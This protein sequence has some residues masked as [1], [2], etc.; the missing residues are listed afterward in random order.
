MERE[1]DFFGNSPER[2]EKK[3]PKIHLDFYF[4]RHSTK[5]DAKPLKKRFAKAD[6][7]SPE[8]IGPNEQLEPVL[9]QLSVGE[10]TLEQ[11][12]LKISEIIRSV[13]NPNN[14]KPKQNTDYKESY[15]YAIYKL[16]EGSKKPVILPDVSDI[17]FGD[18]VKNSFFETADEAD[19]LFVSGKFEDAVKKLTIGIKK[20]VELAITEREKYFLKNLKAKLHTLIQTKPE[21]KDKKD[22]RVLIPFGAVHTG[23]Y[24]DADLFFSEPKLS[25]KFP[26]N[27]YIYGLF[28]ELCRRVA[29]QENISENLPAQAL[30][31]FVLRHELKKRFSVAKTKDV[32]LVSRELVKNLSK[33][34]IEQISKAFA[35]G[36]Q[37]DNVME[38]YGVKFPKNKEEFLS[39]VK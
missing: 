37:F 1:R 33:A 32:D 20:F 23:L 30:C 12:L 10:I 6:V 13:R 17:N 28:G 15:Q 39:L 24:H 16:I 29:F 31:S 7:F 11:A 4:L 34:E 27:P 2:K 35:E 9:N 14:K 26:N 8:L 21:F 38:M 22:I 5:E 36:L 19:K 25:R 18:E 3:E